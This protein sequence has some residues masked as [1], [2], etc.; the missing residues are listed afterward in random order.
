MTHTK[1]ESQPYWTID[2]LDVKYIH[3]IELFNRTDCCSN[4][5]T[6]YHVLVSDTA[7]TG[8][9]VAASKAQSGVGDWHNTGTAPAQSQVDIGR[10][11]RYV[12]IQLE[13]TNTPLSLAEVKIVGANTNK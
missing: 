4:R 3:Y 7:F 10:T 6:N 5:L 11:G 9:T 12:R 2:L 13:G 8:T 1:A